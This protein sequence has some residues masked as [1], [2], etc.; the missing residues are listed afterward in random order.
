MSEE[1]EKLEAAIAK[2]DSA[3][4]A[5]QEQIEELKKAQNDAAAERTALVQ[6]LRMTG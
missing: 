1:R 4:Q 6:T 2:Q 5:L 3:I